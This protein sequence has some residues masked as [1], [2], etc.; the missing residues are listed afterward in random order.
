MWLAAS[1][2]ARLWRAA[3]RSGRL[4]LAALL[5]ALAFL[6]IDSRIRLASIR[7]VSSL[8]VTDVPVPAR[9][10]HSP[11]GYATQQH[12]LILPFFSADGYHWLMQTERMLA[13]GG[14][15]V[16][17]WTGDNAPQGR[18][19]HWSGSTRWW[20]A[21]VAT[22]YRL[23]QRSL[24]P[25]QALERVAPWAG[26]LALA[27]FLIVLTPL[28][29]RRLGALPAAL[30]AIGS[31]A[32]HPLYQ[33]SITGFLDHHNI[34][35]MS[36]LAAVLFLVVGAVR[37]T[38][39]AHRWF[40]AAAL[41]GA[42]G[43]WISAATMAPVL[44]GIGGGALLS[45]R[46]A[47]DNGRAVQPAPELWRA[48]GIAGGS[49]SL[50]CYLLEYFPAHMG[51]RLEVNHPL[52][53]LAWVAAGDLLYRYARGR[54]AARASAADIA[55]IALLPA[56][57]LVGARDTFHILDPFLWMLHDD[58]IMEFQSL[59]QQ[60]DWWNPWQLLQGGTSVLPLLLLGSIALTRWSARTL[61]AAAR[62]LLTLTAVPAA[63]LLVLSLFQVRWL[64]IGCA[65]WLAFL[66][67]AASVARQHAAELQLTRARRIAVVA[68]LCI[69]LVPFPVFTALFPWRQGYPAPHDLYQVVARDVA[70]TLRNRTGDR[71]VTVLSS[72]TGTTWLMYFGGFH[73][74]GTL[75][76]ENL[77]GLKAAAALYAAPTDDAARALLAQRGVT[78]VVL[79]S[80]DTFAPEYSRL[81]RGQRRRDGNGPD[82]APAFAARLLAGAVPSW[83]A[84]IDYDVPG[85]S[86]LAGARVH[87]FEVDADRTE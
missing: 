65:L 28:L 22:A 27:L 45:C 48:W 10:A 49:A 16:R 31:I 35:A 68:L 20:L 32:I 72:P 87:I 33:Y 67:T 73:G 75:Y 17:D 41:A 9:D 26:T 60:P 19:V 53:A 21:T 5:F 51:M 84:R 63:L 13:G 59:L 36:A 2:S 50:L 34:A 8:T 62:G 39:A 29:A 38:R 44:L 30:F 82:P 7:D 1:H 54:D 71:P 37:D 56:F 40:I 6:A 61:P 86:V 58:Y 47:D 15:R 24:T 55:L 85:V 43:L 76:W 64:G 52:Y 78:H 81:A 42:T 12:N 11:S 69:V 14:V 83:L 23:T 66:V 3:S 4:W 77:E 70:H 79:F 80:W 25:A 18:E 46:T 57:I 74:I